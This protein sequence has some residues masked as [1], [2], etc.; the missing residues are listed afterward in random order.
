MDK[1]TLKS[2][3]KSE[4]V[5]LLLAE[6]ECRLALEKKVDDLERY[7]KSFDNPHTPS[8]KKRKKNTEKKEGGKPR[9][10]GKPPGSNGGGLKIPEIDNTEEH[11]LDV[12]PVSGLPLGNPVSS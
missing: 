7:I 1:K 4:L 6:R 12:C 9:F 5:R 2:L 10:P 8:S 3:S 11:K